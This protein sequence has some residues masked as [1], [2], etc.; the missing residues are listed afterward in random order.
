MKVGWLYIVLGMLLG[1]LSL[2]LIPYGFHL[3]QKTKPLLTG[4]LEI[5]SIDPR[6]KFTINVGT[7]SFITDY[8]SMTRGFDLKRFINYGYDY[9]IKIKVEQGKLLISAWI[10]DKE[11]KM[12]AQIVDNEWR[13]NPDNFYDRNFSNTAFEVI[14][15]TKMPIFQIVIKSNN[16]IDMGGIF[17]YPGGKV[18]IT[19]KSFM[20]NPHDDAFKQEM[21]RIFKYPSDKF[22][23]VKQ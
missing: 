13:L 12:V 19:S 11:G 16:E 22:L 2:F 1:G 18:V 23:G 5:A 7:N 21:R 17:Y 6:K 3:I 15:K 10:T 9:P 14:D 8:A 20:V 4:T